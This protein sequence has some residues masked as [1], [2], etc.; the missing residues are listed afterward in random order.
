DMSLVGNI[1]KNGLV[2]GL[3]KILGVSAAKF[4]VVALV[5]L[6]GAGCN[7][8]VRQA[9]RAGLRKIPAVIV[10]TVRSDDSQAASSKEVVNVEG[11]G[12]DDVA[13]A[14][15]AEQG[16]QGESVGSGAG[17]KIPDPGQV[18]PDE[19]ETKEDSPAQ[20]KAA[21]A[22]IVES[23]AKFASLPLSPFRI[24]G[25]IQDS[26]V[27]ARPVLASLTTPASGAKVSSLPLAE[28]SAGKE[29]APAS[30]EPS[31]DE[32]GKPRGLP[33]SSAEQEG[34][35]SG[36]IIEEPPPGSE[37]E[38][39]AEPVA[40][41]LALAAEDIRAE[42]EVEEAIPV[43]TESDSIVAVLTSAVTANVSQDPAEKSQD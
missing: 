33:D 38:G 6:V 42:I 37:E 30:A 17:L 36:S 25:S 11:A 7:L 21:P 39:A 15:I 2:Q 43:R 5:L 34:S 41:S 24:R 19:G 40:L 29:A 8:Q 1:C 31:P 13:E 22:S 26:D 28:E 32:N 14:H 9:E 20:I 12:A 18:L 23:P 35:G 4:V 27:G 10:E 16:F 3:Q